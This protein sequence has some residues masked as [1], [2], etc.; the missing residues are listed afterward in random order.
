[1]CSFVFQEDQ[2][3]QNT[4]LTEE[5]KATDLMC[6][7]ARK[8]VWICVHVLSCVPTAQGAG[9]PK[10]F[11]THLGPSLKTTESLFWG[12]LLPPAVSGSRPA[13]KC[14]PLP[15]LANFR[16]LPRRLPLFHLLIKPLTLQENTQ[17][18]GGRNGPD[19]SSEGMG[20]VNTGVK[21]PAL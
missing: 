14:L 12:P 10:A 3:I 5:P 1:M 15:S 19:M 11:P 18:T 7:H 21:T 17:S 4:Q 8:D 16:E 20:N 9:H 13:G 2:P 6:T